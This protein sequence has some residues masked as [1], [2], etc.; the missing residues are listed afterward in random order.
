MPALALRLVPRL[1]WAPLTPASTRAASWVSGGAAAGALVLALGSGCDLLKELQDAPGAETGEADASGSGG[2]SSDTSAPADGAPCEV[3][4]DDACHDQDTLASCDPASGTLQVVP[5]DELCG[6]Y[7]NFSCVGTQTG[8]HACWCVEPGL[9]KVYSCTEVEACMLGC[10]DSAACIDE[11]F[12]R[13]TETTIRI[14]GALLYCGEASC[15]ATCRADPQAC[16]ACVQ[17]ALESGA[18]GCTVERAL[19]DG[20]RNDEPEPW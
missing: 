16:S 4:L 10:G 9:Q 18:G 11:C 2:G 12:A 5:C 17:T 14:L 13:T 3:A 15:D 1:L 6:S 7:T 8:Q 19:C 20:D